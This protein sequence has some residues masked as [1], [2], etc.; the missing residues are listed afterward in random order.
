MKDIYI[1]GHRNP[2]LDSICSAYGY[3]VL[4]NIT[5]SQNRYHA[6]MCGHMSEGVEK[7]FAL[8]G[9]KPLFYMRDVRPRVSDVM[10]LPGEKVEAKDPIY[11]L[12]KAYNDSHP[13]AFPVYDN[14]S[15]TGLLSIDDITSWFLR[16]NAEDVPRYDFN[17]TNIEAVIPGRMI[18]RGKEN[19]TGSILAGAA[20]FEDFCRFVDAEK[21]SVVVLGY[22]KRYIEHALSVGVPAIIISAS[23]SCSDID[24]SRYNGTVYLTG[25]GTAEVERRLRMTPPV[26]TIM[27]KQGK[28]LNVHDLFDDAKSDLT[29]SNLRGLAVF[30]DDSSF[31][32]FVTR[33]C[34]LHKPSYSVILVDHNEVAQS[35]RG[36]EEAQVVEIIDHHRLDALKTSLPIFIDSEPLGSTCTI[37]YQQFLRHNVIPDETTARVLLT[38]IMSDTLVLRSPTTTQVDKTSAGALAAICG[39]YDI[40]AFGKRLFSVIDPLG[41][42]DPRKAINADFKEYSER[43]V[44]FGIGQ[45][46]ATTLS[47]VPS[48]CM[49]Y[50]ETLDEIRTSRGLDWAMLMIT[51]VIKEQSVLLSTESK[52]RRRFLWTETSP[53]VYDMPGVMSRKKQLLPE[54]LHCIE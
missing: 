27:G 29:S 34:F 16:D 9:I 4:K 17:V 12:V 44:R 10:L 14:G 31:A 23:A 18:K 39:E 30:D 42:R 41:L 5:D 22:R 38:G 33:R 8:L 28:H 2:D 50:L 1:T 13:S 6:V 26:S 45:C 51:D 40:G 47:D 36:I 32:G 11:N 3:A 24:F 21:D 48:Y 7:Q 37:V 19:F 25:L 52:Y 53:L 15:F 46:E 35:I 43:G 20:A 49:K 54:V